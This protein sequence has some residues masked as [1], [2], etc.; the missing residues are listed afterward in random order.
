MMLLGF[1]CV[2]LSAFFFGSLGPAER[3]AFQYGVTPAGVSLVRAVVGALVA[4]SY[5]LFRAPRALV[6]GFADGWKYALSGLF[7]VVFVYYL[8]NIAFVTIPVGLTVILFY[9]NPVWTALGAA[10]LGKEP[11]TRV[12][13]IALLA[14]LAGVWAAV[15]GF[16]GASVGDLDM[17]G[18]TLAVVSGAGFSFFILNGRYGTGREEPFKTFVQMFLWGSLIML[19]IAFSRN[20]IPDLRGL[21]LPG[22]LALTHLALLPTLVSYGLFSFALRHIPGTTAS[23]TSMSEIIFAGVIAWA[24]LG[25]IPTA[26]HLRG[27]LL[28]VAAVLLLL[29]EDKIPLLLTR[30]GRKKGTPLE[31]SPK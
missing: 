24:F 25:E 19:V 14:G 9:I 1:G 26:G 10:V 22:V 7:G 31:R 23:I 13:F 28:I 21:P 30:R 15:G 29:F 3:V 11:F 5:A 27:A 12:R 18:V 8:S 17:T 2:I 16:G 4:G 6:P 20:E